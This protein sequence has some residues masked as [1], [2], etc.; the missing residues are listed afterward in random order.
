M[1]TESNKMGG[2]ALAH[3]C[4]QI[5]RV[6]SRDMYELVEKQ[7]ILEISEYF[8]VVEGIPQAKWKTDFGDIDLL[9]YRQIAHFELEPQLVHGNII[10]FAYKFQTFTFQVDLIQVDNIRM[11]K[12][13]MFDD[14]G[15]ILGQL[16]KQIGVKWIHSGLY[17]T[18]RDP[19]LQNVSSEFYGQTTLLL[20]NDLEEI[21]TFFGF[22]VLTN[23]N[24]FE[25]PEAFVAFIVEE[26]KYDICECFEGIIN[27]K[28]DRK[29]RTLWQAFKCF[30]SFVAS[31]VHER[32]EKTFQT[33]PTITEVVAYFN[34]EKEYQNMIDN[35]LH[36]QATKVAYKSKLNAGKIKTMLNLSS[37]SEAQSILDHIRFLHSTTKIISMSEEEIELMIRNLY[38][39]YQQYSFPKE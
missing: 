25:T 32:K 15:M 17:L 10:S 21:L 13:L 35:V 37:F 12:V 30:V 29:K 1:D 39:K 22:N 34:K 14:F 19:T 23:F 20:S 33:S 24:H 36:L 31:Q 9:V 16:C 26:C 11:C 7:L 28:T 6:P 27:D 18:K 5:D 38:D 3:L 2:N 4:I 8:S